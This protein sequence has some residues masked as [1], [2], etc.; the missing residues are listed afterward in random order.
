M[1][2]EVCDLKVAIED[3]MILHGINV[4]L[5]EKRLTGIIGPNGSGKSTLL[6]T[7]YKALRP[8]F[9]KVTYDGEDINNI[10]QKRCAQITAVLPQ[11]RHGATELQV[12][13]LV[14]MGRYPYKGF[15]ESMD[16][17]DQKK[18]NDA[19]ELLGITKFSKRKFSTLSGGEK[20]LV[21]LAR[22]LVQDTPW[23]LLDEPTNHLDIHHQLQ[24]LDILKDIDK[25]IVIVF[26]DLSLASKYCDHLIVM[27]SG[28]VVKEGHPMDIM[29]PELINDV[30]S[31]NAMVIPHPQGGRPVVLL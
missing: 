31:I 17:L 12:F 20:Q 8:V 16:H 2:I 5:G 25:R 23:L 11:H 15:M 1:E 7:F 28:L 10:S 6:K 21:L 13:D 18:A 26:H 19:L 9:V 22:A 30:Y 29:T 14:M 4:S 3:T 24:L 27:K